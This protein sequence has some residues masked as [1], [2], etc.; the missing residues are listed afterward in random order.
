MKVP[1]VI[2]KPSYIMG[3]PAVDFY[4][5]LIYFI[6]LMF[7]N[8]IMLTF[9]VNFGLWGY[10]FIIFSTWGIYIFL[11]WG[12]RQS[13]PGFIF[14]YIAHRFMQ[15]KKVTAAGYKIKVKNKNGK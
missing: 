11:R 2:S 6:V 14:S 8:N 13:H 10:I 3:L 15:P 7:L 5:V 1:R 12:A 9:G 4:V